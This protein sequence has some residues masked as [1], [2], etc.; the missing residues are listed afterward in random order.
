MTNENKLV[1]STADALVVIRSG[2]QARELGVEDPFAE[3]FIT[4]EGYKLLQLAKKNDRVYEEYNLARYKFTTSKLRTLSN[5]YQQMLF[6][7]SGFDCRSI[8][9]DV[10]KNG[11]T[12]VFEIDESTKLQQKQKQ[13]SLHGLSLPKW[14]HYIPSNLDNNKIPELLFAEGLKH[15][16]PLLVLAEGLFFFVPSGIVK[17]A[18]NPKWLGL[19]SGSRI[20]FDCWSDDRVNG[21]NSRLLE[22]IGRKL[23]HPFPYNTEPNKLRNDLID[24]GYSN[25]TVTPLS[26]LAEEYY[27]HAIL[28]EYKSSWL[29]V[30]A[31]V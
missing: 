8:W 2:Q 12:T 28:D 1:G 31:T 19:A 15:N 14:N 29:L 16:Q 30:E 18:L 3:W 7:G 25:V 10:F 4:E 9:L 13:L 26:N 20:I 17:K 22:S 24:L 5:N 27:K 21:L 6:L 23:F 11:E